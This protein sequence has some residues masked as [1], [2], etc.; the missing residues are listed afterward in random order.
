MPK[1]DAYTPPGWGCRRELTVAGLV[2][3][4]AA[5]M[6]LAGWWNFKRLGLDRSPDWQLPAPSAPSDTTTH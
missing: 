4:L 3:L 1:G 6:L 5:L 2:L